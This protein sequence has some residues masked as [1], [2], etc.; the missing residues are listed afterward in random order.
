MRYAKAFVTKDQKAKMVA[1]ILYEQF[2]AVFGAPVKLL[3]DCGTNFTSALVEEL[4]SAFGIPGCGMAACHAQ[5]NGQA[6][7]FHQT[8]F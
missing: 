5:C 3:S 1:C 4:C 7:R 6:E 2:I 8:L